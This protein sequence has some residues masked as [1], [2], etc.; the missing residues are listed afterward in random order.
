MPPP[1]EKT[2]KQKIYKTKASHFIEVRHCK[3]KFCPE[4]ADM[5]TSLVGWQDLVTQFFVKITFL[6]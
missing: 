2:N 6:Y 1:P 3:C 4:K 5:Y